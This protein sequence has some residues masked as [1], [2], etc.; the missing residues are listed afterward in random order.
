[1]PHHFESSAFVPA[2]IDGVFSYLDDHV[3]L[4]SH[5]SKSSWMM[6]GGRAS[7]ASYYAR[8]CTQRMV[9]DAV[10]HGQLRHRHAE[11]RM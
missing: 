1:M 10:A 8:W 9:Q 5:M 2:P 11:L 4:A 6:G 3:R 7:M